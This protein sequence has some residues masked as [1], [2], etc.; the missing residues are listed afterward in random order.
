MLHLLDESI[1]AFLRASVPLGAQEID[2]SFEAPD[3]DWSAQ[4]NRPTVNLF[5][6]DIARSTQR[7]ESGFDRRMVNGVFSEQRVPVAVEFRYLVTAWTADNNDEH[8]LL[9]ALLRTLLA[10]PALPPQFLTG[11]L[12]EMGEATIVTPSTRDRVQTDLWKALD[13]QLKPGIEI[14]LTLDVPAGEPIPLAAGAEDVGLDVGNTQGNDDTV[15]R[16]RRVAGEVAGPDSVGVLVRSPRGSTRVNE[17][18]NFLVRAAAGDEIVVE[19][20][21]PQSAIAPESGGIRFN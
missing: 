5:L 16:T 11:D 9:G 1:E 2:V 14:T 4:L 17:A 7:A 15:N 8:Q 13:G 12:G 10:A 19:T 21:P 3:K 18:G 6:W 20:D